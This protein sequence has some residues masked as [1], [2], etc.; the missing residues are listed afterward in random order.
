MRLQMRSPPSHRHALGQVGLN[1]CSSRL[2][3]QGRH[4]GSD[5]FGRIAAAWPQALAPGPNIRLARAQGA[6]VF[7]CSLDSFDVVRHQSP[8]AFLHL[9]TEL[10]HL[11]NLRHR[12]PRA[13]WVIARLPDYPLHY[14]V[15]AVLHIR[16]RVAAELSGGWPLAGALPAERRLSV[17]GFR[18]QSVHPP[19][20]YPQMEWRP[21][22][23]GSDGQHAYAGRG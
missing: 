20:G 15:T 8:A 11:V 6:K 5:G 10:H 19:P 18:I 2:P 16:H 3:V 22:R 17:Q 7:R 12:P 13:A 21:A 23:E 1:A 9:R 4:V 14:C